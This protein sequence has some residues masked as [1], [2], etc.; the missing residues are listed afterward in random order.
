[1]E[2][3]IHP[4]G[5]SYVRLSGADV[6]NPR[7]APG[8]CGVA[9]LHWI[10]CV[11]GSS[12]PQQA[13]A[14]KIKFDE[15]VGTGDDQFIEGIEF[16]GLL[17]SG[18]IQMTLDQCDNLLQT[19]A[20][21]IAVVWTYGQVPDDEHYSTLGAVTEDLVY[22]HDTQVQGGILILRRSDFEKSWYNFPYPDPTGPITDNERRWG[23]VITKSSE[24]LEKLR[25]LWS[26]I[27][28]TP[29]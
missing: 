27:L 14:D 23:I 12:I 13:I 22:H 3:I 6:P 2:K 24:D 1:M 18:W 26:P 28:N 20:C 10:S 29:T 19:K 16:I 11:E 9:T 7:V 5:S 8:W 25:P 15:N 21:Q 4:N 17:S